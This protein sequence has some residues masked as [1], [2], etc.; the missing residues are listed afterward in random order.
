MLS[1]GNGTTRSFPGYSSSLLTSLFSDSPLALNHGHFQTNVA[2]NH[3]DASA[4]LQE[5]QPHLAIVDMDIV[6]S[7]TL[8]QLGYP[9]AE[10]GH[11]PAIALTRRG[12]IKS[13]LNAFDQGVDDVL[14]I[15][16]SPE[17]LV[18]R[19]LA[20]VRRSY[21]GT[22]QFTPVLR[23][24]ELEINI[25]NR[26]VRVGNS[27]LHLTSLQ[28]SLLYLLVANAGR[29][30]TRDEILDQLWG[31]DFVAESNLVDRHIR[32]LRARLQN[33]WRR[34]RYI[35]TVPGQGYRFLP[36]EESSTPAA[37]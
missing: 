9:A 30:L 22:G 23:V 16:F 17:E 28:Q 21:Q 3:Q 11:T 15:P 14:S 13:K 7:E 8:A 10:G 19:V 12:D 5:W 33:D 32:D 31:T 6:Q 27:Q 34:P 29:V 24:G 1:T 20:V 26:L 37:R 25:V 36:V 2:E 35:A 18:A 4:L